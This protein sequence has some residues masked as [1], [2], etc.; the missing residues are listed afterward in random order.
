MSKISRKQFIKTVGVAGSMSL[1]AASCAEVSQKKETETK[2]EAEYKWKMVTSWPPNFPV[3]GEACN[4]FAEWVNKMSAGRMAIHVYGSGELVPG[5]ELFDAVSMGA[6][7]FGH[8]AGYYWTGKFK[9]AQFFTTVPFG[10]NTQEFNSW[11]YAGNGMKLWQEVYSQYNL[12]PLPAGNTTFQMGGW[13][14]REINTINDLQGLKMRI[15]GLGGKVLAMAGGT[16]VVSAGSEIYTNLERG[17]LD[18]T[19]WIGP[20]HDYLMGFHEIA[21]YYYTPGWQEP[22]ACLELIVNKDKYDDLPE[23]LQEIIQ[24]AAARSNIWVIAQFTARNNE[25]LK[26]ILEESDAEVKVFPDEVLN[27]LRKYTQQAIEEIIESDEIS[28]KVYEDQLAFSKGVS[29]WSNMSEKVYFDKI[30]PK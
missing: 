8:G 24:S 16:P 3:L 13:F 27:Q 6:A 25:Y 29:Q 21:K 1:L 23:D 4:L 18:A 11:M 17:V 10:M 19:E 30:A 28:K 26:K 12:F 20:Y 5:L 22:Q 9:A 15:P 14:N 2:R 7:E